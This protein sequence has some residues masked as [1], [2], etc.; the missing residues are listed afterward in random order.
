MI[1]IMFCNAAIVQR[2][3]IAF[4][5]RTRATRPRK[6]KR[7]QNFSCRQAVP[8]I[9]ASGSR[10]AA[11]ALSRF[12]SSF[13]V[14]RMEPSSRIFSDLKNAPII[15]CRLTA[16]KNSPAILRSS[17]FFRRRFA[18]N[19]P[20]RCKNPASPVAIDAADGCSKFLF[21]LQPMQF[22]RPKTC[23]SA[24]VGIY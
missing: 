16:A 8:A 18:D 7:R 6:R 22:F 23:H 15:P 9:T 4:L 21:A 24:G 14:I 17:N 3:C 20:F 13:M 5:L 12:C 19:C 2:G 11:A 10:K 1:P